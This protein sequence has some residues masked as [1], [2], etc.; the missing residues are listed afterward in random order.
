MAYALLATLP[1]VNGLY[2]SFFPLL[3][4]GIFGTSNHLAMGAISI[5][6]LLTGQACNNFI[7]GTTIS[8][9]TLNGTII[10]SAAVVESQ[11]R[12]RVA[13]S[14]A[15]LVGIF[16]FGMGFFGLGFIASYFS[17]AFVSSYTCGSAIVVLTS[18]IKDLFGIQNALKFN[19]PLNIP[20]VSL[21]KFKYKVEIVRF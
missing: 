2:I 7:A 19:G 8:A 13:T 5:V 11:L 12:V 3:M 1:A 20:Y 14:L 4:Y 16:Q 15:L 10:T 21:I 6:S 17:D 9:V 18:Q